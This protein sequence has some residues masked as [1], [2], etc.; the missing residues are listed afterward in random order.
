MNADSWAD[1]ELLD[2]LVRERTLSGASRALGVDQTTVARRL[3]TLERR[4]GVA[5][6]DRINGSL[7]PTPTLATVL[8][9]LRAISEEAALSMAMLRQSTA[10]LR[11]RVRVTSVGLVLSQ[12]L[13]PQLGAFVAQHPGITLDF[14]ADN[15][16]LSFER[17]EADVAIRLGPE[18]EGSTLIKNLGAMRFR[19]CRPVG[20]AMDDGNEQRVVRYGEALSH[21]PEMLALDRALP[22]ARVA[23][24]SDRLSILSAAALSLGAHVM[25]PERA[26]MADPRFVFVEDPTVVAERP[27]YLLI[28]PERARVPSVAQVARWVETTVRAWR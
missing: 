20:Q 24:T 9:R 17:R 19:L 3:A 13:A 25:L 14:V 27:I 7:V 1:L 23:L 26:A 10:A 8:G 28:H 15:Q 18:A 4:L 5:M 16:S 21:V 11:G 12:I 2:H 6:F 22:V